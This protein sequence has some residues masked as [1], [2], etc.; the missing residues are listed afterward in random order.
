MGILVAS[1]CARFKFV[2]FPLFSLFTVFLSFSSRIYFRVFDCAPG[3]LVESE[4][5]VQRNDKYVVRHPLVP[6][7]HTVLYVH[8]QFM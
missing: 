1:P 7:L 2:F 5:Y 8:T 3:F 6:I 4:T